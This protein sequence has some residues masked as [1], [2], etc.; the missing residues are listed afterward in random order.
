MT[1]ITNMFSN[2]N[3]LTKNNLD[4]KKYED[5]KKKFS[6]TTPALKQGKKFKKYQR[7][8]KS[9]L[10]ENAAEV[11]GKE[12]FDGINFDKLNLSAHGLTTQSNNIISQNDFSSQQATIDNLRTQYDKTLKEYSDII[13]QINGSTT[14]YL[15]RVNASNP[16]LG[17]NII[18]TTGEVAYVTQQGV[19]KLYEKDSN[20]YPDILLGTVGKNGC[21][22][23]TDIPIN[24]PWLPNYNSS[25]MTIPSKPPLITGTP[26]TKGQSCGNEG[27]NVFVNSLV[28]N[29]DS[30]YVGCYNNIPPS[31]E[32]MFIPV[33]TKSNFA[34]GYSAY[35]SSIYAN[36]NN[37]TGPWN[38][39][40]NNV[41]TFWHS[42]FGDPTTAYNNSNGIYTGTRTVNFVGSN[43][44]GTS[45]KGEYLQ[46]NLPN[47][48]P[49]P[50]TKYSIQ[51]RQGCCGNPNGRDPN[52]WYILGWNA[53][54]A[55][56]YQV[57]YQS[58]V[59]FNWQKKTFTIQNPK[60]YTAYLMLTT[61][62]GAPTA[63]ANRNSVQV[64]T[65]ELYTSSNYIS[66]PKQAM[67]NIGKMTIDQCKSLAINS[68]NK[69]YAIQDVD[70]NGNANC[71]I[72][73]DMAGSQIYGKAY[74]FKGV[75]VWSSKTN[76]GS[77]A[78]VTNTG[79]LSVFNSSGQAIFSTPNSK[80][81]PSNYLGC[82]G[83]GPN[84]AMS[85]Y[86]NGS[87]QYN[88]QQ[89]QQ[90]AQ[91][92]GATYFGLQNSTS[93]TTAQC[94]LSNNLAQTT[95]YGVA[96]NCTQISDGTWSGG[97]FSN[98][99]YNTST[100]SSNYF[101]MVGDYYMVVWRGSN[102]DD[103]QGEI[104]GMNFT[105]DAAN[106]NFTAEKGKYG[107]NWISQG[108]T[109]APGDFVGSPGGYA[110]LIMQTDG[111]LVLYT[112]TQGE[113]CSVSKSLG[114][115]T[116]GAENVNALYELITMGNKSNMGKVAYID[117]NSKL[118]AYPSDNIQYNNTYT[119]IKGMDSS[120]YDIP[121]ASYGNATVEA[122]QTTCNKNQ[123]CAGFTYDT[124]NNVCYPKNSS[125]YPNGDI[126]INKNLDL[127]V[128]SKNPIS[129]PIGVS[130][131][132][133]NTDSVIYQNYINGGSLDKSY[134]LANATSVQKQQLAQLQT[135]MNLIS[136][137]ISN[138]TTKF[139]SG[140]N[141]SETQSK[142]NVI[143]IDDYLTNLNNTNTKI[144]NFSTNMDNI[145]NDSDIV[146]LQRNY[147]YL[148]WTI[149]ATGTV[150]VSMNIVKQ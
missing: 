19:V 29:P 64:A 54:N 66:S 43:G 39:F 120:G 108:S 18:F 46:I 85:L 144:T 36:N 109:L 91:Q 22:I 23:G 93:G 118:H 112:N 134:G 123:N 16:Y 145:L 58:N 44:Q 82:Y 136:S 70:S 8:I 27:K 127:Y 150:L 148:F 5:N 101:L 33:M 140:T 147:D 15:D 89:C 121:Q 110:Y 104:W 48:V 40:D 61:V 86:N 100:P 72:S 128:R 75:S 42:S 143:G 59:A 26:M 62:V 21:P 32:V 37:F 137:Q 67:N 56:W 11:S 95:S 1:S 76:S 51:G 99:V 103:F 79:S 68:G 138:L 12:G 116:V 47:L 77:M 55:T 90:I 84:R 13:A 17:K 83:D 122:C 106:P 53:T 6:E 139:S 24:L 41:N 71:L 14:G 7:K 98:A 117:E 87:Q 107:K 4:E 125:M 3:Y 114:D 38:A 132:T 88:L 25:G 105:K 113:A 20:G 31:T 92:N 133:N 119:Q 94:A 131:T 2:L 74:N 146:V 102:P 60:A 124:T 28:T 126:Q 57:D 50:L 97:G 130:S 141:S 45:A 10:E 115:K 63:T 30:S 69:Y 49:I 142:N 129:P 149:L 81:Q 73:N 35:A 96:R 52:T 34:N 78:T 80:A 65:W 111:N 9:N 135:K